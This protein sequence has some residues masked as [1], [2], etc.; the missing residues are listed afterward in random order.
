MKS[1]TLKNLVIGTLIAVAAMIG[2]GT[3]TSAQAQKVIIRPPKV[4]IV[5]PH[6][7]HWDRY[8]E[9]RV[10]F[11]DHVSEQREQGYEDGF[12]AGKSDAKAGRDFEPVDDKKYIKAPSHAYRRAFVRGYE[13]G[14]RK[15]KK[16]ID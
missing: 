3:A 16:D 5:R 7:P 10:E 12:E 14:Y 2:I 8:W 4:I 1:N 11:F 9:R 6:R 13:D 15:G